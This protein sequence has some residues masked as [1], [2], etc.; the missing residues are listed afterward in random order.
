LE[1]ERKR[2]SN[3]KDQLRRGILLHKVVFL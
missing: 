1:E 2:D 3:Q